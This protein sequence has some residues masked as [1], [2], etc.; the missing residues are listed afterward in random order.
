[1]AEVDSALI[2]KIWSREKRFAKILWRRLMFASWWEYR[3]T[4]NPTRFFRRIKKFILFR[5]SII[6]C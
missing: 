2:T 5:S 3:R 4:L 1:M 6:F